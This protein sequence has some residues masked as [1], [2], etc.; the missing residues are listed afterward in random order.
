M[1]M[2]EVYGRPVKYR[3]EVKPKRAK[4]QPESAASI[5]A[6]VVAGLCGSERAQEVNVFSVFDEVVGAHLRKYAQADNLRQGTL[7]VRVSS[8]AMAHQVTMLR[9]E[10]IT[11]MAAH[12]PTG[13]ITEIRTRVGAITER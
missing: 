10:I 6:K 5:L 2:A 12:L 13:T 8:A 1:W 9:E 3:R 11:K 4:G 7:F